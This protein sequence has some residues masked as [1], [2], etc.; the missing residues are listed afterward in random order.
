MLYTFIYGRHILS[1][2]MSMF[3]EFE[4]K[5]GLNVVISARLVKAS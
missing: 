2:R 5:H 1:K 3:V 4:E